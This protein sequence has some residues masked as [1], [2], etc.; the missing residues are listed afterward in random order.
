MSP[1]D[2]IAWRRRLRPYLAIGVVVL[3][4]CSLLGLGGSWWWLADLGNHFR[5]HALIA[6]SGLAAAGLAIGAR[7]WALVAI[8]IAVGNGLLVM[9]AWIGDGRMAG[10]H[11][12]RIMTFNVHTANLD[13]AALVRCLRAGDPE[14]AVLLEVDARWVQAL[15]T[16]ADRYPTRIHD[17][18]EDN[19]GISLLTRV[20]L[21]GSRVEYLAGGVPSIIARLAGHRGLTVI[22][23]HP[24]PPLNPEY[25]ADRDRQLVRLAELAARQAGAVVVCGDL[26]ITPW[27]PH[28]RSLLRAGRLHD[29]RRGRGV[30]TTWPQQPWFLRIPIDHVLVGEAVAV[31]SLELTPWCGSD[32]RGMVAEIGWVDL[33]AGDVRPRK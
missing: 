22:G 25:A 26:N 4:M 17:A 1:S 9:P 23:T 33:G 24:L 15:E 20:P 21:A 27:S 28:F 14:V 8:G 29:G 11:A 18:R 32:H 7:R 5:V 6:G 19:F 30:L 2:P 13:T 3:G 31:R 16:L 10:D 12:V